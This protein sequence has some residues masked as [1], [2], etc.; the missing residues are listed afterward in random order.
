[1]SYSPLFQTLHDETRPIGNLG[2]A[3][4]YSVLRAPV[5]Y[6]KFM[7]R[8]ERCAFL[9]FAVIWDEDHDTRVID[10]IMDLYTSGKLSPI[11]YI[12][13]RKGALSILLDPEVAL[14]WDLGI[15]EQYCTYVQNLCGC[16]DGD[17]WSSDVKGFG[18]SEPS[19]VFGSGGKIS[20]YLN[21]ID[22]LWELGVKPKV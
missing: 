14:N 1:M 8:T 3:T 17:Y 15:L 21:N 2:R 18:D 16:I 22:I 12:G 11:K 10:V 13:E 20:A 5:W 4:H 7:K 19:L 9:D 6:D